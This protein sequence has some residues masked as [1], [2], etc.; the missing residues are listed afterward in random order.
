MD[1]FVLHPRTREQLSQYVTYPSHAVMLI[2]AD[3]SGKGALAMH[4]ATTVLD[5]AEGKDKGAIKLV[6]PDDKGTISIEVI[7][8]LQHFLQLKT[9]GTKTYR[10]AVIIEHAQGLTTEAQNAFLKV[11]EE[12]PQDTLLIM[13]VHNQRALLPTILSRTQQLI[14]YAP[15]E[16]SLKEYWGNKGKSA[17]QIN[18]AYLLSGGLPG[19]MDALLSGDDQHPLVAGVSQAKAIL[20]K[21]LFERMAMVEALSKKKDD[22][23][24]V[25]QALQ[26]IAQTCLDQA[27]SKS[28]AAKLK[29]W[30]HILKVSSEAYDAMAKNANTKLVLS[31]LMLN[32]S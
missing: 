10:R 22:A 11:L 21:Q 30:H 32:L 8:D 23:V 3:G 17:T 31:N 1:R 25:V 20:Q 6:Q 5:V 28:D 19:L 24:F 26:H 15:S 12:P 27:A 2:G 29:Q 18:Q 7:R 14:V 13:T 4:L 9:I 16:G